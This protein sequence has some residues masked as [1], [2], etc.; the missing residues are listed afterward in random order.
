MIKLLLGAH[1][2]VDREEVFRDKI[3]TI[4]TGS[5]TTHF[6]RSTGDGCRLC[7]LIIFIMITRKW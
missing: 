1:R 7:N 3:P 4:P 6:S 5:V 2:G